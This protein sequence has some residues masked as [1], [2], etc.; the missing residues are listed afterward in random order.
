[1]QP[2]RKAVIP[3]AG[4]GTRFLP[5]TKSS[6]KEM[7]PVVDR[8]A[9]QYVVEEAV[10]AG[11][12]DILIITGRNKRAVEDHFDRNF[13]LEHYLE[14]TGKHD[15]AEGSAVRLRPRRHPLRAPARSA[16]PR[17]RGVG[18]A[19]SR[20]ERA[21]RGAARRRPHGRRRALLRSM[22]DVHER[23]G[24]SVVAI[25]EVTPEEISSYGCVE[26][27]GVDA[28]GVVNDPA[29][30]REAGARGRAVEPRGHR[31]LRVHARDLRR[32]RPHRAG[33]A[34]ASSSSPTRSRCCSTSRRCSG[35]AAK[36]A[37][38]TSGTSS[39]SCAPTS[40]SRS[41]AKISARRSRR[42][43]ASSC[44]DGASRKP[45]ARVIPLGDAQQ[46]ILDAVAPLAPRRVPLRDGARARAR[47]KP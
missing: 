1:M 38:T 5:A 3:A 13:E 25:Q 23:T 8:P 28:D 24:S 7:L 29:H 41:T 45:R 10:Q 4:L 42:G 22:L 37:A 31:P 46:R 32:A 6:P 30:R 44:S 39:T 2:V 16:R 9:I 35:C 36:A 26:P 47:A 21:V 14:T 27:D 43:F 34:A 15:A 20:R 11:L 18:R 40:S 19:A 17:S 33:R 12:T